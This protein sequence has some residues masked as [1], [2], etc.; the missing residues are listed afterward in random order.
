MG[1]E[2]QLTD[3]FNIFVNRERELSWLSDLVGSAGQKSRIQIVKAGIDCGLTS[4]LRRV[5]KDRHREGNLIYF[6]ARDSRPAALFEHA[7][8]SV[9]EKGE[10][11]AQELLL[12][13]ARPDKKKML[14]RLVTTGLKA[15][16]VAG[17][18]A[19]GAFDLATDWFTSKPDGSTQCTYMCD[20]YT[21][22]LYATRLL[23]A[24]QLHLICS[25][26][27]SIL[28]WRDCTAKISPQ[29]RQMCCGYSTLI[30]FEFRARDR[31]LLANSIG[32]LS[33]NA[34]PSTTSGLRHWKGKINFLTRGVFQSPGRSS[35]STP[36]K[37]QK[38]LDSSM[39]T[40]G[41]KIKQSERLT[42][43]HSD[44]VCELEVRRS[45]S[46]WPSFTTSITPPPTLMSS[47]SIRSDKSAY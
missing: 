21:E 26:L 44:R 41:S 40:D 31:C 13:L 14:A 33:S 24:A 7:V 28:R 10:E 35:T 34:S 3:V 9:L 38:V 43:R 32:Y 1:T 18:P 5:V 37:K 22:V 42:Q 29:S 36:S 47:I 11:I 4:A 27:L 45:T 6:N 17:G 12:P 25:Y 23:P 46:F 8:I 2:I 16:P 20:R 39:S 15:I 30:V 19:S